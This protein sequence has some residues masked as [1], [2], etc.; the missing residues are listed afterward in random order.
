MNTALWKRWLIA[1]LIV[2]V[3]LPAARAARGSPDSG[4]AATPPR[5]TPQFKPGDVLSVAAANAPLMRGEQVIATVPTGQQ[6]VVVDVRDPWIGVYVSI[7]TEQKAG[8]IRT[9][10]FVPAANN[11]A[12][13]IA[14]GRSVEQ[15]GGPQI[16]L[17]AAAT[18]Q[19][20]SPPATAAPCPVASPPAAQYFQA[21]DAGYYGRHETD[22]NL[23]TWEPWMYHR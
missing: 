12:E 19:A 23:E 18:S 6:I 21:Y 7:G 13:L 22:P 11:Q 3:C 4:G 15:Q 1:G 16:T 17:A 20:V 5:E 8:W 10:A 14:A 9:T 2:G